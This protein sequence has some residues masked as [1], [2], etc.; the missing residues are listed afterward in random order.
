MNP[1]KHV[2]ILIETSRAYGRGLLRGV[3]RFYSENG[4]WSTYFEPHDLGKSLPSWLKSWKG[5]GILARITTRKMGLALQATGLPLIDLRGGGRTLGIPP[6]GPNT[7][8]ICQMA[9]DHLRSLGIKRF[10]FC[11]G[12]RGRHVYDDQREECFRELVEKNDFSCSVFQHRYHGQTAKSWEHEQEDLVGWLC[13]LPKPVGI[14][15]CHDDQGQKVLDACRRTN[16]LVPDEVAVIGSDNSEFLCHLSIPSLSS[17]DVNSERIGYEAAL[18]LD[19]MMDKEAQFDRP[20]YF[21]PV[22]VVV[23][24]STEAAACGDPYIATALSFIRQ[25]AC[26]GI[27]VTEVEKRVP[28]SRSVLNRRFKQIVGRSP[29]TEILHVQLNM[30]KRMLTDTNLSIATISRNTGFSDAKYFTSV[31]HRLTGVTPSGYRQE[32]GRYDGLTDLTTE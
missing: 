24:Q 10:A 20:M 14:M 5:T 15:A 30:A 28:L 8:T 22:G 27:T 11:G 7:Q 19:R 26:R 31:F 25:E 16:L 17:I 18:L 12:P 9:F 6:F 1:T 13:K 32:H 29:K 2:A 21:D 3:C 23:R 4:S